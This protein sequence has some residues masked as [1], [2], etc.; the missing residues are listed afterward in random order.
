MQC[1]S[2]RKKIND[3]VLKCPICGFTY[4]KISRLIQRLPR[5]RGWFID[6]ADII[7][8]EFTNQ[9]YEYLIEFNRETHIQFYVVTIPD[10]NGVRPAEYAFYFLNYYNIGGPGHRGV[11]LILSLKEKRI[12]CEVGYSLE[13]ILT[14][15]YA[16]E[17]LIQEA[18]PLLKKQKYGEALYASINLI[19]DLLRL[20]GSPLER[21]LGQIGSAMKGRN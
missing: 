2:C 9:I 5:K 17:I 8:E 3:M 20:E 11:V 13:H 15:E 21:V 7:K 4:E 18:A 6:D 16:R 12:T 19:G 10:S 1:P 14:D